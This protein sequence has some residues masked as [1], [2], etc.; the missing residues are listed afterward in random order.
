[1]AI[2]PNSTSTDKLNLDDWLRP[3]IRAVVRQVLAECGHSEAPQ[4]YSVEQAA[5]KLNAPKRWLYEKSAA[6]SIPCRKVGKYV[7]FSDSDLREIEEKS[8]N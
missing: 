2:Q 8:S 5:K 3:L 7:R 4:L 1:M 6:G